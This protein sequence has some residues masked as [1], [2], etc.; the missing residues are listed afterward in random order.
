MIVG[1]V[2]L[3]GA[4]RPSGRVLAR[5]QA[6][7]NNGS[8]VTSENGVGRAVA[9][10]GAEQ[11]ADLDDEGHFVVC[12]VARGRPI[13]LRYME[14]ERFTDTTLVIADSLLHAL[15]WRPILPPPKSNPLETSDVEP[16]APIGEPFDVSRTPRRGQESEFT[17][18]ERRGQPAA[19]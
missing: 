14:N 2:I 11:R 3:P 10:N 6:T 15:E 12:G 5:W 1:R 9:V 4:S 18:I 8:P 7:Y 13:H 16:G 19:Q 17:E